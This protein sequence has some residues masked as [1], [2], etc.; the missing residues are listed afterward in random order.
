MTAFLSMWMNNTA[1]TSIMLPVALSIVN[2]L[3]AD[4][5]NSL[6][7]QQNTIQTT[8]AI[9]NGSRTFNSYLYYNM[10]IIVFRGI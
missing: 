1:S 4:N 6:D 2:E 3:D 5:E 7:R 8:T 10:H 9:I